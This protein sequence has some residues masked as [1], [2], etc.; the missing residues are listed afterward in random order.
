MTGVV[1]RRGWQ[2]VM[3]EGSSSGSVIKLSCTREEQIAML[4]SLCDEMES[5]MPQ[6]IAVGGYVPASPRSVI[7]KRLALLE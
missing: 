5:L 1:S 3:H 7:E 2:E 6:V 4:R